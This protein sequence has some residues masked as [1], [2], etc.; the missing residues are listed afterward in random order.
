M[1]WWTLWCGPANENLY[2][3]AMIRAILNGE[4]AT[5]ETTP[6]LTFGVGVPVSCPGVPSEVL[7]PRKHVG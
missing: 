3:R 6:D 7:Q 4:L 2:T 1:E 5:V